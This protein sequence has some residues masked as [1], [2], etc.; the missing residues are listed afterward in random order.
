M[1]TKKKYYVYIYIYIMAT[2]AEL[3]AQAKRKKINGYNKMKK[4]EL[5]K[6]LNLPP[7]APKVKKQKSKYETMLVG[8]L[9]ELACDM[10]IKKFGSM[11][12]TEL[13]NAVKKKNLKE[14]L[15]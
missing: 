2:V 12:K 10:A 15:K 9:R 13:I 4:A 3:K 7:E 1:Y 11:K 6:A 8:D 5:L 14:L